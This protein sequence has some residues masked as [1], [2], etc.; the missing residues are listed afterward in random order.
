MICIVAKTICQILRLDRK[1]VICSMD[2]FSV[3][4]YV[5]C[6]KGS[7]AK[8]S[9]IPKSKMKYKILGEMN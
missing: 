3:L 6:A 1:F 8:F 2:C 7:I 9:S 5:V 4:V